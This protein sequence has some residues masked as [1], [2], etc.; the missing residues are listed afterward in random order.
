MIARDGPTCVWCG[1]QFGALV[2]PTTEHVV[3]R[4]KGGPSWLQNEV[5]ACG[6]CNA[7]RGHLH[8]V[9]WLEE[10]LR[11][12]WPADEQRLADV[13][14]DLQ[15]AIAVHGGHRRASAYAA[16]VVRR[17]VRRAA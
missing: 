4:V 5:A 3:P 6:R 12:G 15:R 8:P 17:L 11:R 1:R 7:E 10:C 14:G 16:G 9:E 13:L 2:G